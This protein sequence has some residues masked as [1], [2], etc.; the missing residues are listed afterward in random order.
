MI[1]CL[2]QVRLTKKYKN[3]FI[4][5]PVCLSPEHTVADV[6]KL[7]A[8]H[9]FSGIPITVSGQIGSLLVGL[10]T[11]R[12]LDFIKDRS[13]KLKDVM[14][15]DLITGMLSFSF[16]VSHL[17]INTSFSAPEGISLSGANEILRQSKKGKLPVVNPSG[18]IVALISRTGSLNFRS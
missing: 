5:D 17:N 13:I 15:T 9:G 2:L 4:T 8:K 10:V 11:S 6:D 16:S 1:R 3:G 7:K 14:T 12:D 18:E